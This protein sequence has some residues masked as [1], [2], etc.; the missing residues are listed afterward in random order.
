M[1]K[2]TITLTKSPI[3]RIPAQRK[4]VKA[5]GLGKLG[6]FVVKE[7][8]PAMRGMAASIAHLVTV[9][10]GEPKKAAKSAAPKVA[11]GTGKASTSTAKAAPAKKSSTKSEASTKSA[12]AKPAAEKKPAATKA[13]AKSAAK[14]AEKAAPKAAAKGAK[15]TTASKVAE[16]KEYLDANGI[17]YPSTAKKADLLELV[18]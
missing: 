11:K 15:P 10:D 5:L 8:T 4:T 2:I 13:P 7:D 3:A 14:P 12:A 17:K 6:S 16:I 1:A 9:T 18:K